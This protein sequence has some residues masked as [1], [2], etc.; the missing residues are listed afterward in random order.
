MTEQENW[1]A[2][3]APISLE[4][5]VSAPPHWL[6]DG[7]ISENWTLDT[8]LTA[9]KVSNWHMILSRCWRPLDQIDEEK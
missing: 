7:Q 8:H 9:E 3:A 6:D 1:T 2:K 5:T 4:E